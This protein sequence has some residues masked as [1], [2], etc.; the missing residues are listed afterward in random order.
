MV[1]CWQVAVG[2]ALSV[3]GNIGTGIEKHQLTGHADWVN[4]V[5]FSPDGQTLASGSWD[6]TVRLWDV[7]SGVEK[8]RLIG[9]TDGVNSV[10][11]SPDG[12]TLASGSSDETVRL[13]D[14]QSGVEKRQFTGHTDGVNSVVFS[15]DGQTLASGGYD[16]TLRLWDV[17]SGV[18]KRQFT[19]HTDG[20]NSVVFSPDGQ[21]LASGSSNGTVLLWRV[22]PTEPTEA[23]TTDATINISPA[24]VA[25]PAI[26]EQ[27][28]FSLNIIDGEAVAGYQA[29]VQFDD[30]ALRYISSTN[31]DFLPA[32][33]IV[34]PNA[35][36]ARNSKQPAIGRICYIVYPAFAEA[37]HST[38]W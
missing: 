29:T 23:P 35:D 36:R 37:R 13:W 19:G 22:M 21:T 33:C 30:T 9:H 38:F 18:E 7:Q 28:E 34:Q 20:V 32:V 17:Q 25:S 4:S 1:R 10:V 31:G 24:S 11:F 14:V 5:V 26:G 27:L 6:E 3:C 2:M 15:P 12:Q 8:R 16:N